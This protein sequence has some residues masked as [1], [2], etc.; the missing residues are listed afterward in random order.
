VNIGEP[1]SFVVKNITETNV[2]ELKEV[3]FNWRFLIHAF[4]VNMT[5]L[6]DGR[7]ANHLGW[8]TFSPDEPPWAPHTCLRSHGEWRGG[9]A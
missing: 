2:S 7:E 1:N 9:V 4:E 3:T 5:F 8:G 6:D